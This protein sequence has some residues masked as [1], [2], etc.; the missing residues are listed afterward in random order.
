[1]PRQPR[2]PHNAPSWV[3]APTDH[4]KL[5]TYDHEKA[6]NYNLDDDSS[7]SDFAG[8]SKDFA[9]TLV[10]TET[11]NKKK[12]KQTA[13]E[14]EIKPTKIT[15]AQAQAS[16]E[17]YMRSIQQIKAHI[18]PTPMAKKPAFRNSSAMQTVPADNKG[19]IISSAPAISK[20]PTI[21]QAPAIV[22]GPALTMAP[23][24]PKD[25][26]PSSRPIFTN[27]PVFGKYLAVDKVPTT[28]K[29][30]KA[31]PSQD[32]IQQKTVN[33]LLDTPIEGDADED[34]L[35]KIAALAPTS[36]PVVV[37]Y[38]NVSQ[39]SNAE[40]AE[41][42]QA[43]VTA[44]PYA[45]TAWKWAQESNKKQVEAKVEQARIELEA[46]GRAQA[47]EEAQ[48]AANLEK[49]KAMGGKKQV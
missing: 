15:P 8:K 42:E 40:A 48:L 3:T 32:T 31:Q 39:S 34:L 4:E 35:S 23:I 7:V 44:S 29:Q 21:P 25:P 47:V 19:A 30:S 17:A 43:G 49:I 5:T 38:S 2:R 22:K 16:R 46:L 33:N 20:G 18:T 14:Q 11:N 10:H 28:S 6:A 26:I 27:G 13:S 45:T 41:V 12:T 36:L 37:P 24:A 1:M 9:C